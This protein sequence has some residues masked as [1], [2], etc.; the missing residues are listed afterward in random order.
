M[1]ASTIHAIVV[2]LLPL[3]VAAFGLSFLTAFLLVVIALAWRWAL[4]FK[5]LR[6]P[7]GPDIVL[8][9]IG[10]SHYVEKVRWCLDRLGV[11]Y[12]ERICA[13]TIGAFY[14]GRTV[15]LLD[16]RTGTV[17]SSIGN[18]AEILRY[19]WGVYGHEKGEAAAFL[20]P[21]RE[22]VELEARLD[23]YGR[24]LQVW[25]YSHLLPH[26]DTM[27]EAWGANDPRVPALQR[28]IVRVLFPVQTRLIA[29]AF[30]TTP[31]HYEKVKGRIIEL[32]EDIDAAVTEHPASI[33]GD[34]T[35]NYTDFAFASLSSAWVLPRNF[36]GRDRPALDQAELPQSMRDDIAAFRDAA[37]NAYAFIIRLYDEERTPRGG[38]E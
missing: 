13:G 28:N 37:P 17:R 29:R 21:T 15:P 22:R 30:G 34:A 23:R 35:P 9:G 1:K 31:Q 20:E 19:L 27:L 33:L 32:L 24:Q 26:K 3:I 38:S 18:S 5:R 2:L 8:E 25:I 36:A 6:S 11:D 4:T 7:G 12:V 14:W 10:I 16:V